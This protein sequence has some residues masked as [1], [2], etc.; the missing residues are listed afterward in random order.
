[1]IFLLYVPMDRCAWV[2]PSYKY[3]ILYI[4]LTLY[5]FEIETGDDCISVLSG[6]SNVN[7]TN[8]NCGPGHGIRWKYGAPI[9][10]NQASKKKFSNFHSWLY[11]QYAIYAVVLPLEVWEI[12]LIIPYNVVQYWKFGNEYGHKSSFRCSCVILYFHPDTEWSKD[13]DLPGYFVLNVNY[14]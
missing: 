5:L 2:P 4:S 8:V 1:M 3:Y 11:I 10:N 6:S 13:Q 7:I 9:T 12:N 14:S